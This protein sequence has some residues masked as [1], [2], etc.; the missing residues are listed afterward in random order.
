MSRKDK[1]VEKTCLK[2]SKM[3]ENKRGGDGGK[4]RMNVVVKPLKPS[5]NHIVKSYLLCLLT[6]LNLAT[7]AGL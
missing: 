6:G 1:Q 4:I 3:M 2:R 5:G 7:T